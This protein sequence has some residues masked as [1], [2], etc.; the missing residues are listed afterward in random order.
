M[1]TIHQKINETDDNLSLEIMNWRS[2]DLPYIQQII[3][4]SIVA[5]KSIHK[6][7]VYQSMI[8]RKYEP[9]WTKNG[10]EQIT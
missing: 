5:T 8:C 10:H 2:E 1:L 7:L 3:S 6:A 9:A 4:G